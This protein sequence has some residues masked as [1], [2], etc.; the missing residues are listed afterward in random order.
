MKK[1]FTLITLLFSM[2]IS[3]NITAHT[4]VNI[5]DSLALV[6]L[7]NSTNGP[8]WFT[9]GNWLTSAPLRSWNGVKVINGRVVSLTAENNNLIGTIPSSL[10]NLTNLRN[11]FVR[12]NHLTDTIP[13]QLG[14]LLN[15]SELFLSNNQLTGTIPSSFGNLVNMFSLELN[16]N[17]L[18]GSIPTSLGNLKAMGELNLGNNQLSGNIPVELCYNP[19]LYTL[20]I[21]RNQLSGNIPVEIGNLKLSYLYLQQNQLTGPIPTE[22]GNFSYVALQINLSHNQLNGSIP[23]KIGYLKRLQYLDLSN[24]QLTG[25]IPSSFNKL[26]NLGQLYLSNNQLT[27]KIPSVFNKLATNLYDL[28]LSNNKFSGEIPASIDTLVYL[29]YL[30]LDRNNLKGPIPSTIANLN[31]DSLELSHNMF[32]FEGMELVEQTFFHP[33]Y[34]NQARIP[35]HLNGNTLS[36]SAGGTLSNNTYRWFKLGDAGYT[37]ITGDSVFNP[38]TS[39]T[40]YVK[41][42]NSIATELILKS[43]TIT[44]N[45]GA[46]AKNNIALSTDNLQSTKANTFTVYPNPAKDVLNIQTNGSASYSLITEAGR[47]VITKNINN[48]GAIDITG[49]TAGLYY[50]KNNNT[51][52]VKKVVVIK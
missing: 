46:I 23:Y 9:Q 35:I 20:D 33:I 49:I 44:Y 7:Y 48:S 25:N 14:N 8:G 34:N 45:S 12:Y 1:K 29:R 51:A 18:T 50:L 13:A 5:Q 38:T 24:N 19:T 41:V 22:I 27:G 32:T 11:L 15:M 16:D 37:E 21:S 2:C 28:R 42:A 4:Q 6:D 52:E 10:G 43:D 36:V 3:I 30:F 31:L 17:Q 40:Y 26:L 47:I 39:G